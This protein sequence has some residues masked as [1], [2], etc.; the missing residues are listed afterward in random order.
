M[1]NLKIIMKLLSLHKLA[2]ICII[3]EVCLTLFSLTF[4][5]IQYNGAFEYYNAF[6]GMGIDNSIYFMGST[7]VWNDKADGN[8]SPIQY[9]TSYT[10]EISK[11]LSDQPE[12]IGK[13]TILNTAID[14]SRWTQGNGFSSLY[15]YDEL[16]AKHFD[17][18]WSLGSLYNN[19]LPDGK[20]PCIIYKNTTNHEMFYIG[21]NLSAEVAIMNSTGDQYVNRTIDFQVVNIVNRDSL[22]AFYPTAVSTMGMRLDNLFAPPEEYVVF[23]PYIE[24]LFGAVESPSFVIYLDESITKIRLETIVQELDKYG[25]NAT[26][27]EMM[28]TTKSVATDKLKT[29]FSGF[30][31]LIGISVLSLISVAFL[32][33]KKL[34]YRF[35]IYNILGCSYHRSIQIYVGYLLSLVFSSVTICLITMV[36]Y[37]HFYNQLAEYEKNARLS[38][39]NDLFTINNGSGILAILL[40]LGIVLVSTCI[41]LLLMKKMKSAISIYKG[42]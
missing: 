42:N 1:K 27:S 3:V 4:M 26:I 23:A 2:N 24:S 6:K 28:Q 33:A 11:F 32:N 19:N 10:D 16:T 31:A 20:V 13:S 9:G 40:C 5:L 18:L 7:P 14:I 34:F 29:D 39:L 17:G 8:E 22:P 38:L 36:S 15:V 41:N 25:Y 12:Y 21:Q 35:N 30:I 37:N